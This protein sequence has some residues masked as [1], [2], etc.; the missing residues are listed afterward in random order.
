MELTKNIIKFIYSLGQKKNRVESGCFVVEGTKAVRDTW[1][2]FDCRMIVATNS[3]YEQ[4]GHSGHLDKIY[5]ATKSQM[6][7]VSQFSNPSDVV[8]VYEMPQYELDMKEIESGLNIILDNVQDPGN[9]GTIM[10]VADWFGV[11]N[12]ICS[13]TTVDMFNHKVIQATMGAIS[14]VKVHYVDLERFLERDWGLPVYGTYLDGENI[15]EKQLS[16]K[17]FIIFGNEGR[18]IS[19]KLAEFVTDRLLIPSY[20]KDCETSESLN[21]S[22]ATAITL[23][24]FRRKG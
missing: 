9:M 1:D 10:R 24:E 7:R 23:S 8:A 18:G 2:Y 17:G 21:V 6:E 11:R 13:D 16:D 20:P 5:I 14:R 22:I 19:P 4:F 3:W 12:I 15:Y